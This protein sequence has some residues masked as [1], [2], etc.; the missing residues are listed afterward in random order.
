M[1]S[2]T[3]R[4]R[5]TAAL[6]AAALVA[7][8][9]AALA[10][11]RYG[12]PKRSSVAAARAA[13]AKPASTA[14]ADL[15]PI[16]IARV[17]HLGPIALG[18]GRLGTPFGRHF[19]G[20]RLPARTPINP[21]SAMYVREIEADLADGPPASREGYLQTTGSPPLYVV[22]PHQPYVHV[23]TWIIPPG[24]TT[25]QTS[26][27]P[28]LQRTED[29]VLAE[30]VPVPTE[31]LPSQV[32][33]RTINIYQPSSGRLWELWHVGKD[34]NGNW[35]VQAAGR[36]DHVSRSDGIFAPHEGTAATE[37]SLAGV[38]SRIEE[39]EAGRIDHPLYLALPVSSVLK[40]KVLPI[41][42]PGAAHGYSWPAINADG[43]CTDPHCIPEGLR[44]R[45]NPK[46]NLSSLHLTP[47][48]RMLAI[49]AKRYGFIVMNTAGDVNIML[50]NPQP[51]LA[52]GYPDPY[53]SLFGSAYGSDYSQKVMAN[54]PWRALQAL[55]Y[56]YGMKPSRAKG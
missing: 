6:L 19:W 28:W 40:K 10:W 31:A 1:A 18:L 48:A 7:G 25:G 44:F 56:D 26:S 32:H 23:D 54:F 14:S 42:T 52:A 30:G 17:A 49:A 12:R 3:R 45:L 29:N 13:R 2:A 41:N 27:L 11:A 34:A 43:N 55:P 15:K 20:R 16:P 4:Q 36:I 5:L 33:D 9:I 21:N 35:A 51:Y 8:G 38:V 50:G 24:Q 53:I 46:L 22:P 37:D 39:L 47:V